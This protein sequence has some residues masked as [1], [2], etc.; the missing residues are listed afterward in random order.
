M[1]L[2]CHLSSDV[3]IGFYFQP[4][5]LK[6]VC[7]VF[8]L[9]NVDLRN[10]QIQKRGRCPPELSRGPEHPQAGTLSSMSCVGRESRASVSPVPCI[11][12]CVSLL[13]RNTKLGPRKSVPNLS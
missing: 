5:F 4:V 1:V 8:V 11:Q 6:E 10:V 12:R 7:W 2:W 3:K 13:S 9:H